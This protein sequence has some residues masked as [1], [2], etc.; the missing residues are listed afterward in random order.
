MFFSLV[1]RKHDISMHDVNS[2]RKIQKAETE[3]MMRINLEKGMS[4]S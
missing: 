2:I 3:E 1:P 4:H